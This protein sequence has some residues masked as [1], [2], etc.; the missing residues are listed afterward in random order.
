[1]PTQP[2]PMS[3]TTPQNPDS[4]TANDDGSLYERIDELLAEIDE[5]CETI[6]ARFDPDTDP[7]VADATPP[8][9]DADQTL[10]TDPPAPSATDTEDAT[11]DT[12][13][14]PAAED[15]AELLAAINAQLS[16]LS[17][18]GSS[19]NAPEGVEASEDEDEL[20]AMARRLLE[21]E[22]EPEPEPDPEPDPEP[23]PEPEAQAEAEPDASE[24]DAS[25][26]AETAKK[27]VAFDDSTPMLLDEEPE[28]Q[29]KAES[30]PEADA[31]PEPEATTAEAPAD[32]ATDEAQPKPAS[33]S[34][35]EPAPV[36]HSAEPGKAKTPGRRRSAL[37]PK[38]EAV[39][40][41]ALAPVADLVQDQPPKIRDSLGWIGSITVFWALCLWAYV[42]LFRSPSVPPQTATPVGLIDNTTTLPPSADA[43]TPRR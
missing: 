6:E 38:L 8:A 41:K 9:A 23:E 20:E 27:P 17:G 35:A 10:E 29:S 43:G 19:G 15:E 31:E 2:D 28:P 40:A 30:A 36:E 12:E 5:A 24:D 21:A 4:Q 16:D 1:M 3:E 39:A 25:P 37:R 26:P 22:A 42:L 34:A 32:A 11:G 18:S 13:D 33:D 7:P 14:A